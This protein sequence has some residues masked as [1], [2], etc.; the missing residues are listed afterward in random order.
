MADLYHEYISIY[1]YHVKTRC[2]QMFFMLYNRGIAQRLEEQSHFYSPNTLKTAIACAALIFITLVSMHHKTDDNSY[3]YNT[4]IKELTTTG[5]FDILDT[6]Q[7]LQVICII[8]YISIISGGAVTVITDDVETSDNETNQ[9]R[10]AISALNK[11][12][13]GSKY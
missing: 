5:T 4:V 2:F 7:L 3:Q 10:F 13:V 8:C 1:K 9:S 6:V 11:Y 12:T